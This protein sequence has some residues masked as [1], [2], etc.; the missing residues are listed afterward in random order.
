MLD[1]HAQTTNDLKL[2]TED[3]SRK[4]EALNRDKDKLVNDLL[5]GTVDKETARTKVERLEEMLDDTRQEL[6]ESERLLSQT[7]RDL[8][9]LEGRA[10]ADARE[11]SKM[12]YDFHKHFTTLGT[13][14]ALFIATVTG[15]I[16]PNVS[17]TQA[18]P[19]LFISF[20]LLI[21][22]VIYAALAMQGNITD[23]SVGESDDTSRRISSI[24]FH[25]FS[26]GITSFLVYV[27]INLYGLQ[28]NPVLYLL[29]AVVA[30][31]PFFLD[32]VLPKVRR[33]NRKKKKDASRQG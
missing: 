10:V 24:S 22:S 20:L 19:L 3:R 14:S 6:F 16:F 13:G 2:R 1:L 12:D 8:I 11:R 9:E 15:I 33:R 29:L 23:V 25:T 21:T 27:S 4:L 26:Y 31:V 17:Q 32:Y 18:L 5:R 7:H 30:A 28:A